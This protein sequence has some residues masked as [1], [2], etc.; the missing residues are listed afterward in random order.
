MNQQH[1]LKRTF[2]KVEAYQF[3]REWIITGKLEPEKD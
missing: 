3:L 1:Q 2:M